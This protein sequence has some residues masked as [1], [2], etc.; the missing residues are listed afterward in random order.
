MFQEMYNPPKKK[1][2]AKVN[3]SPVTFPDGTTTGLNSYEKDYIKSINQDFE[4][5]K[6]INK[7]RVFGG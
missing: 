7:K 5:Q 6:E 4:K 1:T 2:P 3:D